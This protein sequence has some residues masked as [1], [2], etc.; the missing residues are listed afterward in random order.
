M[1]KVVDVGD[2]ESISMATKESYEWRPFDVVICNAGMAR[3]GYMDE[4]NITYVDLVIRT[5]LSRV[6]YT[7]DS[8]LQLMKQRSNKSN[9]TSIVLMG[10]LASMIN[11]KFESMIK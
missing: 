1:L 2:Y 7:V 4:I 6:V 3:I 9:L 11:P 8:S 10:S 5:N